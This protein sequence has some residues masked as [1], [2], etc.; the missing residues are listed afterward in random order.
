MDVGETL[1][2]W[3]KLLARANEIDQY[4][5]RVGVLSSRGGAQ[6][7][8]GTEKVTQSITLAE[9]AAIH[10]FG[11]PKAGIPERS[12]IR[13]TLMRRVRNELVD[14]CAKLA[15]Q[16]ISQGFDVKRA[17]GLL[18]SWASAEVKKTITTTDIPPPLNAQTIRQKGSSRP[19]VDTGQLLN[20][21]TYEIVD[22]NDGEGEGV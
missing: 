11:S 7:A 9:L 15:K 1:T 5:V 8:A 18:G 4:H 3:Q 14:L 16:I 19:L 13:S 22:G 12:F 21:I 10:E 2:E 20:S 17:Y 6:P